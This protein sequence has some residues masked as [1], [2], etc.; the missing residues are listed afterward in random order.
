MNIVGSS[1]LN[2][3]LVKDL[4]TLNNRKIMVAY[5][6]SSSGVVLVFLVDSNLLN[7]LD[8]S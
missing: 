2:I 4:S 1:R 7:F 3:V 8:P 5:D 6:T